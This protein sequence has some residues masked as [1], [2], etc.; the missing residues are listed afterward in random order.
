M[1]SYNA[2]TRNGTAGELGGGAFVL[3][4]FA[5]IERNVFDRN[6]GNGLHLDEFL[7]SR[8]RWPINHNAATRNTEFGIFAAQPGFTGIGN[9]AERNGQPA[10]CFN[11]ACNERRR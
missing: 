1:I 8:S 7:D 3:E 4:G 6:V 11:F 5:T 10:Q 2:I 9:V